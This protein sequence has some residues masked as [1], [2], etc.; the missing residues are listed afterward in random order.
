[1]PAESMTGLDLVHDRR[2]LR[3]TVASIDCEC[4][5]PVDCWVVFAP[6]FAA[7]GSLLDGTTG[8]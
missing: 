2:R 4:T 7:L 8:F 1:M 6:Y 5:G 3:R